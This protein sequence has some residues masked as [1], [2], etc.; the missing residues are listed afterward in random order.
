MNSNYTMETAEETGIQEREDMVNGQR[1]LTPSHSEDVREMQKVEESFDKV[2][3]HVEINRSTKNGL[4]ESEGLMS[5]LSERHGEN[6]SYIKTVDAKTTEENDQAKPEKIVPNE[7][8]RHIVTIPIQKIEEG[9]DLDIYD[10]PG[11]SGED[12]DDVEQQNKKCRPPT[13]EKLKIPPPILRNSAILNTSDA[14]ERE[15]TGFSEYTVNFRE[16]LPMND[17][18]VNRVTWSAINNHYDE[19]R[20]LSGIRGKANTPASLYND[21]SIDS[22]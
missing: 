11:E 12:L 4:S 18:N 22:R 13:D 9:D 7:I 5:K 16:D 10:D 1:E 6:I 14:L 19:A 8:M 20:H 21:F 3:N 2:K 15:N 17:E